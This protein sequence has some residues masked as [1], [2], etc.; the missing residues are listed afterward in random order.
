MKPTSLLQKEEVRYTIL[1]EFQ[2]SLEVALKGCMTRSSSAAIFLR[3]APFIMHVED[4][5]RAVFK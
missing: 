4:P 1:T 3:I 5:S 2:V